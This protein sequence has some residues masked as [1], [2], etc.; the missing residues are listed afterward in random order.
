MWKSVSSGVDDLAVDA[1]TKRWVRLV[2]VVDGVGP[3][4][5]LVFFSRLVKMMCFFCFCKANPNKPE[6]RTFLVLGGGS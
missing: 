2:V 5:K 6:A 3:W 1:G 4:K